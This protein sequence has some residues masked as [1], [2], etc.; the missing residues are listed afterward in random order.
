MPHQGLGQVISGASNLPH[1]IG[2]RRRYVG[3]QRQ[4]R[5][6]QTMIAANPGDSTVVVIV[7]VVAVAAVVRGIVVVGRVTT[8][9]RAL[10]T[11]VI[12]LGDVTA[13]C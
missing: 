2:R 12:L 6:G 4:I 5:D 8:L 7:I 3:I 13:R 9:F 1:L 11:I 10:Q